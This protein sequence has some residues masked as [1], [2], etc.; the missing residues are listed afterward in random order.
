MKRKKTS[1]ILKHISLIVLLLFMMYPVFIAIIDSLK[2]TNEFYVNVFGWPRKLM[3]WNYFDAWVHGNISIYY[4]NSIIVAFASVIITIILASFASFAL[5]RRNLKLKKIIYVTFVVGIM[6]PIQT[7]LITQFMLMTKLN[8]DNS[9][10]SLIIVDVVYG[11]PFSIFVMTG[12]F[13]GI[14]AE[15]EEAAYIDGCSNFGLYYYITMPLSPSV[16]AT[17]AIFRFLFSWN[18]L[19]FPLVLIRKFSLRTIPLG[20][21]SFKGEY[22]TNYGALF[23]AVVVTTLPII[24]IYVLL[25]DMFIQGIASGAVKG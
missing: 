7:S 15:I 11:L 12:F 24:I 18:D 6:I 3:P 25:Q 22:I 21:L 16:I 17:V 5:V 20:L 9:L 14:P 10:V 13:K 4:K 19:V 2:E 8:L 23:A 1:G